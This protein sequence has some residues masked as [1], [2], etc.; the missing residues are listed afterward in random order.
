M[1]FRTPFFKNNSFYASCIVL[2]VL[3]TFYGCNS[4]VSRGLYN[5]ADKF[6]LK[7][8][9][10]YFELTNEQ[11]DRIEQP[12]KKIKKWHKKTQ[13]FVY[14]SLLEEIQETISKKVLV[15]DVNKL[16]KRLYEIRDSTYS[17]V[18]QPMLQLLKTLNKEQIDH[19]DSYLKDKNK[20]I[21]E[22][23]FLKDKKKNLEYRLE[24]AIEV[25][26]DWFSSIN[27][28]QK[29]KIKNY[30]QKYPDARIK[31]LESRKKRQQNLIMALRNKESINKLKIHSRKLLLPSR[32]SR[33]K[34]LI[35]QQ[36]DYRKVIVQFIKYT[37]TSQ[38]KHFLEKIN[39]LKENLQYIL[40]A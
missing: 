16:F 9:N 13:L 29:E 15:S 31:S 11:E 33:D 18:E 12:L 8:L 21:V 10:D 20:E 24:N 19:F 32:Y 17:K 23:E 39:D 27:K 35:Q 6:A 37:S 22:K 38:K 36:N 30:I 40:N 5:Y 3:L 1:Y 28:L 7:Y 26:E 25:V 2:I 14:I 4:W 34:K